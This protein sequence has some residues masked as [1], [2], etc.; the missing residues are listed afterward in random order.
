M[1]IRIYN[2]EK[3]TTKA[4]FIRIINRNTLS[5]N[6]ISLATEFTISIPL[7]HDGET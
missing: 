5:F 7:G 2:T 1:T 3:A 6:F 4:E